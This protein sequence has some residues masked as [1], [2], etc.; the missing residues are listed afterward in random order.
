MVSTCSVERE[1]RLVVAAAPRARR[2]RRGR[3]EAL[4]RDEAAEGSPVTRRGR[5]RAA[6][7]V[8]AR[9]RQRPDRAQLS[10]GPRIERDR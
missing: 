9:I 10:N 5:G 6:T 2:R 1:G 7:A 8:M 3:A 4:A